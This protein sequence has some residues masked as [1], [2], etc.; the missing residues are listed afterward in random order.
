MRGEQGR[1]KKTREEKDRN[2]VRERVGNV[3][4]VRAGNVRGKV[5]NMRGK[6]TGHLRRK[7]VKETVWVKC[8]KCQGEEGTAN[9][10]VEEQET[11]GC[12]IIRFIQI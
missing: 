8:K 10:R 12:K 4:A 6:M 5:K 7:K 9:V 2:L 11:W 3:R 1:K